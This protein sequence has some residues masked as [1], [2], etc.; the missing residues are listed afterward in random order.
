MAARTAVLGAAYGLFPIGWII[1]NVIFLYDLTVREGPLRGHA[2]QPD[3]RS[4]ATAASSS[5]SSPSRFGAFF[6]GAAGLRDAG[7]RDGGHPHRPRLRAAGRLGPV[8]H[9]Q[10]GAG[11]LRRAGHAHRRPGRR[12]RPRRPAAERHGRPA[13]AVLLAAHPLL[14]RLG[15]LRLQ[16]DERRSGRPSSWPACSFAVPQF[17]I[18]NFHGPWLAGVGAA[19]V[20]MAAPGAVPA[21]SGSRKTV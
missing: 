17:L 20:S 11:G 12:D 6:E 16:E 9:R 8:A 19:V 7:G 15:L 13:A 18:S 5:C 4:P 3:R 1:L 10:H 14:A 2:G 21:E